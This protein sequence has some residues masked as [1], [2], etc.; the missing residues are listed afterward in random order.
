MSTIALNALTEAE[1]ELFARWEPLVGKDF[2]PDGAPYP[3]RYASAPVR[4]LLLLKEPWS[5]EG[6]RGWDLRDGLRTR[7]ETGSTWNNAARW[8]RAATS[9]PYAPAWKEVATQTTESRRAALASVA[10]VNVKKSL[11]TSRTTAKLVHAFARTYKEQIREQLALYRPHVTLLC[12]TAEF[13]G[14]L[15]EDHEQTPRATT[16]S[17][18]RY[19]SVGGL[20]LVVR[21]PHPQASQ[22][23]QILYERLVNAGSEL[24]AAL[25][26]AE[27]QPF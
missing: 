19:R 11:G 25:K 17:G 7:L 9:L 6:Q 5:P 2:I 27:S 24:F 13:L 22:S 3:D 14:T 16:R 4:V 18:V 12:G 20:G 8:A 26:L 23:A 21:M 10:V 15:F 1:N